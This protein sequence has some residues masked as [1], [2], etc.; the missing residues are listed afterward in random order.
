MATKKAPVKKKTP[1]KK[2]VKKVVAKKTAVKRKS[3]LKRLLEY[4]I[5][6]SVNRKGLFIGLGVLVVAVG[7]FATFNIIQNNGANAGGVSTLGRGWTHLSTITDLDFNNH[8]NSVT[9][10]YSACKI[11]ASLGNYYLVGNATVTQVTNKVS[12]VRLEAYSDSGSFKGA[13]SVSV[14]PKA[15]STFNVKTAATK[16]TALFFLGV[17]NATLIWNT[18][19]DIKVSSVVT[20]L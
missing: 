9:V 13:Y 17:T 20:C 14:T 15:G 19:H 3:P 18:T 5:K 6:G 16:P 10:S 11:P 12:S 7:A 4:K 2:V 8:S 1:V